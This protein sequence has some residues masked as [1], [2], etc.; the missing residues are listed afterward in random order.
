VREQLFD[1]EPWTFD[2]VPGEVGSG[3]LQDFE[4]GFHRDA[5]TMTFRAGA[6]E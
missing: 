6:V 3:A 5:T 4:N 2:G 1:V